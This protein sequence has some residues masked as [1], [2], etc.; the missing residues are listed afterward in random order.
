[1]L[2]IQ[3]GGDSESGHA[4]G[5]TWG[6]WEWQGGLGKKR[7]AGGGLGIMGGGQLP[8]HLPCPE[9]P[10]EE[11]PQLRSKKSMLAYAL[12]IDN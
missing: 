6:L 11:K 9:R 10:K 2:L 3:A 5:Q 12:N 8:Y 4:E 1:M 7:R